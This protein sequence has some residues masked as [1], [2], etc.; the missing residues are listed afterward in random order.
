MKPGW[1]LSFKIVRGGA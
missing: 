1:L